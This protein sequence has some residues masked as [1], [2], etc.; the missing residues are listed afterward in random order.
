MVNKKKTDGN[1]ELEAICINFKIASHVAQLYDT[2]KKIFEEDQAKGIETF[3]IDFCVLQSRLHQL[4]EA[5]AI[6]QRVSS[7]VVE[8]S[9]QAVE[10]YQ[11]FET[12]LKTQGK[13]RSKRPKELEYN[14]F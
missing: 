6:N 14:E 13:N 8:V 10:K 4:E 11:Q 5:F 12:T 7:G 1:Q 3:L 2:Y 9:H